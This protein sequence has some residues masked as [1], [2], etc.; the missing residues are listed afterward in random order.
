MNFGNA[1]SREPLEKVVQ[2]MIYEYRLRTILAAKQRLNWMSAQSPV[3]NDGMNLIHPRLCR[4]FNRL[5]RQTDVRAAF[6]LFDEAIGLLPNR[7]CIHMLGALEIRKL[8]TRPQHR[9][10]V[11]W[12]IFWHVLIR[13]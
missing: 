9:F 7:G 5:T 12:Q 10:R 2:R 13:R 1:F 3:E 4:F 11:D 8:Q 6:E